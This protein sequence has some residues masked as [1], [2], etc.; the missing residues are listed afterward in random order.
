VVFRGQDRRGLT[1]L[2]FTDIVGSSEVAVELGDRGW[3]HLQSR[4]HAEVRK[5]LR[6]HGGREVD[7]A[8]DGFFVTFRS[9]AAGVRCAFAIVQGVRELGLNVRAGL[10]IGETELAG[11][12]VGGIAVT[13]AARVSAAAGPGQVLATDTIVHLV[14]GSGL[15]FTNLGSQELKGVPGPFDL[16]VLSAVDGESV[17]PPL[18]PQQATE[19]RQRV[20]APGGR[21]KDRRWLVLASVIV[22]A[23]GAAA[24]ISGALL[25]GGTS[26]IPTQP[27]QLVRI[28]ADKGAVASSAAV[29][30]RPTV[31]ASDDS[32][33][34]TVSFDQ[35]TLW[36]VDT[37]TG[38]A[39]TPIGLGGSPTGLAVGASVLWLTDGFNGTLS[40]VDPRTDETKVVLSGVV[41]VKGVVFSDGVLWV[42]NILTGTLVRVDP[43]TGHPSLPIKIGD[44]PEGIAAG[45]GAIWVAS[46]LH[47]AVSRVD[48]ATRRVTSIQLRYTPG[49]LAFGLDALW[50]ANP[51]DDSVSQ[52]DPATNSVVRTITVGD[53]PEGIAVGPDRV[54][55]ANGLDGTVDAIDPKTGG[56]TSFDIGQSPNGLTVDQNADVWVAVG[57]P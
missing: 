1:T 30:K 25:L 27:D 24:A 16:F 11:E 23:V 45:N 51:Q 6:R 56:V 37:Q 48:T 9:P 47:P 10:H 49:A 54:W 19:Y 52:I 18:D 14:A 4:H 32:W 17:G 57:A 8:G 2:L 42:S 15:E 41:G 13:I 46:S 50:V 26:A 7:T 5:Q 33:I 3:H 40:R 31:V 43:A 55:V 38:E 34:W 12:K 20:S 36:G 53:G 35:G 21:A 39:R 44:R 22:V 29:G 28:D